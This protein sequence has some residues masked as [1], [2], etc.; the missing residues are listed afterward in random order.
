VQV[1]PPALIIIG[2]RFLDRGMDKP[3]GIDFTISE[4]QA[5]LFADRAGYNLGSAK[6]R[7]DNH[8]PEIN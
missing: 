7:S 2:G 3:D 5:G 1:V 4:A 6:I 8:L